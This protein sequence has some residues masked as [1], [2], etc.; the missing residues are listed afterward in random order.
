MRLRS[1]ALALA[2]PAAAAR[3]QAP[4]G[5]TSQPRADS[6]LRDDR[7]FSFYARGPYRAGVPRPES[8]LGYDVGEAQTQYAWQER[9][10]LA[11]ADAAKDRV[12]V[13]PFAVTSERR[14]MRVYVVSSPENIARLD[15]I[16]ADLDA[17]ADPRGHTPAELDAIAARA[18]VVVWFSGSVHGDEGPGFEASMQL[19]YQLAASDEPATVAALKKAIVVI[20]PSSN[21]D[22]HERFA[23]WNNSIGVGSPDPQGIEQQRAQPWSVRGR[24]NHYRFDMNRD[25]IATTQREVQGIVR[26]M[27][28]WHPMVTADLHGYTTQYFFAPAARP[29]NEN[30]GAQAG[31]WLQRIGRGNAA[32]FDRYGWGYYVRDVYDLYYPGYWDT[33]PALTGAI[34]MTYETD[35]GAALL[36]RRDDGTLLSLRDGI[37]KHYVAAMATLETAA[38]N[39]SDRVSGYLRF[40]RNARDGNSPAGAPSPLRRVVFAPGDDPGRAAELA[41]T[42][43]RAGIEVRR[44][45]APLSVARARPYADYGAGDAA[46]T[47]RFD[48]GAYVVDLAQPQ[49][50]LARAILDPDPKLD[51]AFQ[52]AQIEKYRRNARRGKKESAEDYEFYDIT[53]WAL[54]IAFGVDA[55]YTDDGAPTVRGDLLSLPSADTTVAS[56][57]APERLPVELGGGVVAGKPARVAYLFSSATNGSARLAYHLLAEGYRVAVATQ[58]I[59]AGGKTW[60]RGSYVVRVSRNDSTVH[61]RVDALAR[62]SGVAVSGI[63]SGFPET[64]QYGVYSEPTVSLVAPRVAIVA[65]EGISQPAYGAI[66]WSFERRYGIAFTPIALGTVATGDLS[67][68]NVILVPDASPAALDTRLGKGG[69]DHLKAWLQGGGTLITMGGATAWAA[70]ESV[71]LTS[72]RVVGADEKDTTASARP[73]AADSARAKKREAETPDKAL[74][75]MTPFASPSA[76]NSSPQPLAGTNF[77]AVLDRTHWLTFGYSRPRLVAL[78]GGSTFLKLSKEGTNVAVFPSTGTIRRGGFEWPEN[79]ERLLRGTALVIEEPVGDGHVVLFANEPMFRGWWRAMDRLVLNGV[80]LGPT[81]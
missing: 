63:S 12:R 62:E 16:R 14:T 23:V 17:L 68:Y 6:T 48:A 22:G 42:L 35:G 66:W 1:L 13:E 43:L 32:A 29:V 15:A 67:K 8:L 52:R 78:V 27:L 39:S 11:I 64:A 10:L 77:E 58:P 5:T 28:R 7:A 79:T 51:S 73:A 55:Y 72:A 75:T 20:N 59:E 37:A 33:W 26:E 30:I 24:F 44:T 50:A 9:V 81:F 46:G 57:R 60:P 54:P 74:E 3:A 36:K 18:P 38:A 2:I 53:A 71:G 61:D 69:L 34:G 80:L 40:R 4:L 56:L 19:L 76:S 31:D 70:R 49:G 45:T 47:R 65:D 41:A 21:P 25:V